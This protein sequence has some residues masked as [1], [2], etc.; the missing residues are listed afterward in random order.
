MAKIGLI[1]GSSTGNTEYAADGI[2]KAFDA[3]EQGLVDKFNV[4]DEGV[5]LISDYELLVLGISTWDDGDLQYDWADVI[6][7][8]EDLDLSGKKVAIFG[9]GDQNI[10]PDTFQ[11]A[12]GL[13]AEPLRASGAE[14]V[15]FTSVDDYS[16]D[17]SRAVE[18][19]QF[20]GLSLDEDNQSDL[21]EDRIKA[22]VGQLRSEFG[23]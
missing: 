22:W 20:I 16:F 4:A 3:I 9:L 2:E 14:L 17:E 23:L 11:D 13:L 12:M 8:L 6:E 19:D 21:T 7:D 1:F 18:N 5:D 15:G 10:Y